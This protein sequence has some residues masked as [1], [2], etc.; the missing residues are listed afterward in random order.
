MSTSS[1]ITTHT[2]GFPRIGERRAL[3]W[4]L[5][6][7]WRGESSAQALQATAKSVRAQTFHAH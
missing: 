5:E 7:H 4:A 2:L 1:N 3:K 6:S